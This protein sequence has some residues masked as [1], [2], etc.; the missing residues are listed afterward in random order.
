MNVAT[1]N[2]QIKKF[3]KVIKRP[4]ENRIVSKMYQTHKYWARKPWYVVSEY[5][6]FFT[7]PGNTVLDVFAGSGVTG[8]ESIILDRI[9][10]IVD[11]NPIATFTSRM[12]ALSP[13]EINKSLRAFEQI[14]K[15]CKDKINELYQ[16]Q[17]ECEKCPHFLLGRYFLRGPKFKN[18]LV[19]E[20]CIYCDYTKNDSRPITGSEL[21]D[22]EKLERKRV[23]FW[24]PRVRFP[25]KF[26]KDRITYKGIR[27]V[28]QLFTKRNLFALSL[29]FHEIKKIKD[30]TSKELLKL[31]F[32][33]TL[34]HVSKL[35][36]ENVRPMAVNNYWVPDDW[37]EENVWFRFEDRFKRILRAKKVSNNRIKE[38]QFKNL[39]IYTQSAT[40]LNFLD[41]DSIDYCFNDPPYG[42][43][44]QYSELSIVWNAWLDKEFLPEE[45]VIINRSQEKSVNDYKNLLTSAYKG[46]FRVLKPDGYMT[47]CFHNKDFSVWS[48]M[49]RACKDAGFLYINAVPQKPISKSFTQLWARNSP[50]TDLL[51][52]FIK[53]GRSKI[54]VKTADLTDISLDQLLKEAVNYLNRNH[55][56]VKARLV[57]DLI[58]SKLIEAEFYNEYSIDYDKYS[59]KKIR[60][61]LQRYAT[62]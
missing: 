42:D 56:P 3:S 53:P 46:V 5:I 9:A 54:K 60:N 22:L 33:N 55:K 7:K 27:S 14:K 28:H 43:S 38:N 10:Y 13:V 57:Y 23:R 34:L 59:I 62:K 61:F 40:N 50:R 31:A 18:I 19:K 21:E 8:I 25:I 51:I 39:H 44:I 26:D 24:Y 48:A 11:L 29:L 16:T 45:E 15:Q 20:R 36:S 30:K 52:N 17:R 49:L 2:M 4:V 12:T 32:S 6:K 41:D 47:V 37:I 58:L 1:K 35:K